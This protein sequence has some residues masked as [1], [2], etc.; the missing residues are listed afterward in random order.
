MP[1]HS[2]ALSLFTYKLRE[3]KELIIGSDFRKAVV[4]ISG[5]SI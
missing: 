2:A 4:R 3:R 5:Q 1:V